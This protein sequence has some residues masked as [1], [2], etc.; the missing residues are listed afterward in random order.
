M[1]A[2]RSWFYAVIG[3]LGLVLVLHHLGIDVTGAMGS[4]VHGLEQV[5]GRPL[6]TL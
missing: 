6:L 2:M 1:S 5:L 4:A 3:V